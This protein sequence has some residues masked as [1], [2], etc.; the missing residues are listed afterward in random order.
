M[1]DTLITIIV[2]IAVGLVMFIFP[3]MATA[4]QNDDITQTSIQALI[5]E[6]VNTSAKEGK[7]T[8]TN[9]DALVQNLYATGNTYDINLEVHV[10]D[11]N[12][13][14]KG[15]NVDTIGE[16]IYVI[17]YDMQVKKELETTGEYKLKQ[18]DYIKATVQNTNI[19]F[20]TQV[21]NWLYS[22]VG[23]DTIAIEASASA[24]VTVTGK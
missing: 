2:V 16:N 4:G 19:T 1:S 17:Y 6:F 15:T 11:D 23:R 7:I 3:L 10:L 14:N 22:I 24:L 9:Y 8:M 12:P 20:G 5:S 13:G 21:K 18:G